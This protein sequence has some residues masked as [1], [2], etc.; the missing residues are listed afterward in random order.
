MLFSSQLP[1]ASLIELCRTLR[2]NLGAGLSLPDVFRQQ[3]ERGPTAVRPVA[4]RI[5]EDLASGDSLEK[6]LK[7]EKAAF[8]PMFLSMAGVGEQ[9]GNLPEV[10]QEL[11]RYYALQDKLRKQ[12]IVLSFWPLLQL[13]G[14]IFV[15]SGMVF[16]LAILTPSGN[17]PFDPLGFGLTGV[18]GSVLVLVYSFG[19]LGLLVAG[20]LLVTRLLQQKAIVDALVLHVPVLGPCLLSIALARF[21]L[22]LRLTMDTSMSIIAALRLSLR[23]TGNAAFAAQGD[24]VK[25][26]LRGGDDL[27]MALAKTDLFPE[28]FLNIL[29]NAEEGGR[30]PEVMRHQAEHY[31]EEAERRLTMLMRMASAGVWLGT[32]ALLI[33][34]I[35]SMAMKVFSVYD[36]FLK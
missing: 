14:A 4:R 21:C 22:A 3:S 17:Q 13:F 16:L 12:F 24:V 18:R 26:V 7:R 23:A 31:Q 36:S 28:D 9:T 10:F 35:F 19:S 1:L 33:F 20:Y 30:L 2:H 32:A 34:L 25:E 29:A 5:H 15:I 8:P 11:E 6:A 27:T